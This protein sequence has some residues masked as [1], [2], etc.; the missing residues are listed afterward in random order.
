MSIWGFAPT[1]T[2]GFWITDP[3]GHTYGTVKAYNIGPT[4]AID[5]P[6][7]P[8]DPSMPPGLWAWVFEG[9]ASNHQSILYFRII[10]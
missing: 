3:W 10:P 2:I 6:P 4:G 8:S 9:T 1:E 7:I 5:F